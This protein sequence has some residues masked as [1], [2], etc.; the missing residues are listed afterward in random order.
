[1]VL[2]KNDTI[3]QGGLSQNHAEPFRNHLGRSFYAA[4]M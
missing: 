3:A 2:A 1:M 4:T